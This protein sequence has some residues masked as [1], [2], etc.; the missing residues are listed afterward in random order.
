MT[1]ATLDSNHLYYFDQCRLPIK[2]IC[3]ARTIPALIGAAIRLRLDSIWITPGC[4]LSEA[5]FDDPE[6]FVINTDDLPEAE[7]L[8]Q[9]EHYRTSTREYGGKKYPVSFSATRT[10]GQTHTTRVF[11]PQLDDRWAE[12]K[13]PGWSLAQCE[14]PRTLLIAILYLERA[15]GITLGGPGYS[16]IEL[17]RKTTENHP[18][19]WRTG[20]ADVLP[21]HIETDIVWHRTLSVQEQLS[22]YLHLYDGNGKYLAACTGAKMP[23]RIP[24]HVE[25]LPDGYYDPGHEIVEQAILKGEPGVWRVTFTD[26]PPPYAFQSAPAPFEERWAYTPVVAELM[27]EGCAPRILEG[28]HWEEW[29]ETLRPWAERL[30]KIRQDLKTDEKRFSNREA[31]LIAQ[32]MSKIIAVHGVGWLDLASERAKPAG[33][34]GNMHHPDKRNTIIALVKARMMRTIAQFREKGF[35]PCMIQVDELG[36]LSDDPNPE[37]AVSGLMA[38]KDELGG[39]KHAHTFELTPDIIKLFG[40]KN[41]LLKKELNSIARR[42]AADGKEVE[43]V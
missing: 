37:T 33:E 32:K 28:Y 19:Y 43:H 41:V 12:D 31:A 29:H 13:I 3:A 42:L 7:R 2:S 20:A 25:L 30:W 18:H 17:M 5:I 36:Y 9:I 10:I 6:R 4:A 39:F 24:A 16:G 21:A 22:K 11:V 26:S 27:R 8:G 40:K 14:N 23:V 38:R 15:L 35:N 1:T 34:H